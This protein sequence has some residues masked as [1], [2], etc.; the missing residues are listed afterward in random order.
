M[1]FRIRWSST[2]ERYRN[3]MLNQAISN[4]YSPLTI[5]VGYMNILYHR[6]DIIF[7]V[8]QKLVHPW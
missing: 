7:P 1:R 4:S 6:I 5:G 8:I 2:D 3:S